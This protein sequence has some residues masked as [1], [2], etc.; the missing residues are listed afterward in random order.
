MAIGEGNG[1]INALDRALRTALEPRI[2][3]LASVHLTNFKV[4]IL[5]E[6]K[7]TGAT[8]RVLLDSSDGRTAGGTLG[9]SQNVIEASWAALLDSMV[10]GVRRAARARS[11]A[12][13][14]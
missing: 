5:D 13:S 14:A 6:D 7:G 4:R 2:P 8:T 12:G 9:V 10:Y 3:E 11:G 1:P